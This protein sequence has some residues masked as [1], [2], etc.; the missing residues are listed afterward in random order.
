MHPA[1]TVETLTCQSSSYQVLFESCSSALLFYLVLLF[2]FSLYVKK[3]ILIL[4]SFSSVNIFQ[5]RARMKLYI[6]WGYMCCEYIYKWRPPPVFFFFSI[7]FESINAEKTKN[8]GIWWNTERLVDAQLNE[9]QN[10]KGKIIT[11]SNSWQWDRG[12][13]VVASGLGKQAHDQAIDWSPLTNRRFGWV[14]WPLPVS[15]GLTWARP[16]PHTYLYAYKY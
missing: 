5:Q 8:C 10:G 1:P 11:E 7:I 12:P 15:T 14:K 3:K 6:D 16:Q 13:V 9:S 2:C 4:N